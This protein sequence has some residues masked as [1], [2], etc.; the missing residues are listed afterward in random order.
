MQIQYKL[1]DFTAT[2]YLIL[3][4]DFTYLLADFHH[5]NRITILAKKSI[6][7]TAPHGPIHS[8]QQQN[9]SQ[10][11]LPSWNLSPT[12]SPQSSTPSSPSSNQSLARSSASSIHF[13]LRSALLLLA[14]HRRSKD[15]SNSSWVSFS[16]HACYHGHLWNWRVEIWQDIYREREERREK[17]EEETKNHRSSS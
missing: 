15:C 8:N 7:K 17:R 14:L 9:V 5:N 12:S 2:F 1:T 6:F 10:T 4:L 11:C 13:S 3:I 16:T